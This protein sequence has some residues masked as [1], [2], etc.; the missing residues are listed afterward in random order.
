MRVLC[1]R[2]GDVCC[3]C[4][5][6]LAHPG[7]QAIQRVRQLD[8]LSLHRLDWCGRGHTDA[9]QHEWPLIGIF[10]VMVTVQGNGQAVE[11]M[12]DDSCA[13]RVADTTEQPGI[14][15]N[16]RRNILCTI[17]ISRPSNR[18]F[19][20][21]SAGVGCSISLDLAVFP[22]NLAVD[23]SRGDSQFELAVAAPH[24]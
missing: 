4:S 7:L 16:S 6:P 5:T 17:S 10:A 21:W 12:G 14:R 19:R 20:K 3:R 2:F 15:P 1:Q 11:M 9:L 8:V 24:A 13:L 22:W 23:G 18:L